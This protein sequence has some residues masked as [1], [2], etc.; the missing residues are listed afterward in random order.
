M[1]GLGG[2]TAHHFHL[3]IHSLNCQDCCWPTAEST[4]RYCPQLKQALPRVLTGWCGGTKSTPLAST[5]DIPDKTSRLQSSLWAWPSPLLL[6]FPLSHAASLTPL[7]ALFLRA[8]PI[9]PLRSDLHVRFSVLGTGNSP[10]IH[11]LGLG[12]HFMSSRHLP[13][14]TSTCVFISVVH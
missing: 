14:F 12:P 2:G 8:S 7:Q 13:R 9:D 3:G 11:P 4:P 5:G 1:L 6:L 10:P